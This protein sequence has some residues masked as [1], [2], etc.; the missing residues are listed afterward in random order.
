MILL[1][2][3][4]FTITFAL[5]RKNLNY[6]RDGEAK[7][8]ATSLS[9]IERT[10][11]LPSYVY[12]HD[13]DMKFIYS[14]YM[15]HKESS[16]VLDSDRS[17]EFISNKRSDVNW[18]STNQ[19]SYKQTEPETSS[20]TK[21]YDLRPMEKQKSHYDRTDVNR[22]LTQLAQQKISKIEQ[23]VLAKTI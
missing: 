10:K 4:L 3:I 22:V 17:D 1:L 16:A 5:E 14:N 23:N 11:P 12:R 19:E 9:Y 18:S 6:I 21:Y 2:F 13:P 15:K 7:I 8:E 20:P